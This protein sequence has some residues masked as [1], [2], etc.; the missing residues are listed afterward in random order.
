M[1]LD[2]PG[3]PSGRRA[4]E[5]EL[6][7]MP[8]LYRAHDEGFTVKH[9]HEQLRKRRDYKLG[10]TVRKLRLHAAGLVKRAVKRVQEFAMEH[11]LQQPGSAWKDERRG[12]ASWRQLRPQTA[13]S[14]WLVTRWRR[15]PSAIRNS[16]QDVHNG[17]Q[18]DANRRRVPAPIH[19][20]RDMTLSSMRHR[21]A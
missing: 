8:G 16:L 4:P 14:I 6:A 12:S 9:F 18:N 13:K 5:A 2:R 17:S 15:Q 11:E 7:R 19:I 3:R 10:Y 20:A 21:S 1:V